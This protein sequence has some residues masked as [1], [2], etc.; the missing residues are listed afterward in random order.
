EEGEARIWDAMTG[1]AV[2]AALKHTGPV[3]HGSFSR[4]GD[5]VATASSDSARVWEAVTGSPITPPLKYGL[6]FWRHFAFFSPDGRNVLTAGGNVARIWDV[7]KAVPVT[8]PM[9]HGDAIYD[10]SYSPDGQRVLTTSTDGTA[11]LWE[12]PANE[13]LAT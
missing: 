6:G 2:T 13:P 8:A 10:A 7:A 4:A 5:K 12:L 1:R 11:R 3:L 9:V